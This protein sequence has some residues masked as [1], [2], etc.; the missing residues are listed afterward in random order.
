MDNSENIYIGRKLDYST[1]FPFPNMSF[2]K[3]EFGGYCTQIEPCLSV[4]TLII[5]IN[6]QS[7]DANMIYRQDNLST[8]YIKSTTPP[9]LIGDFKRKVYLNTNLYV[10]IGSKSTY[11]DAKGWRNFWT[12]E[13]TTDFSGMTSI[14]DVR[15]Q[16]PEIAITSDGFTIKE[17]DGA[18]VSVYSIDGKL[19]RTITDYQGEIIALRSGIYIVEVNGNCLKVKI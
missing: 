5:G 18:A 2:D 13:E 6:I 3:I 10:P 15:A 14:S 8:I 19:L 17:C 16:Q 1:L 12:I 11:Q 9:Q 7:V 4:D